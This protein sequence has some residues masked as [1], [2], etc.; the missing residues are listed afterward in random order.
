MADRGFLG[1]Y[2]GPHAVFAWRDLP[3]RLA[4]AFP[5]Y[6]VAFTDRYWL[7]PDDADARERYHAALR[8]W[9]PRVPRENWV[10]GGAAGPPAGV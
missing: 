3:E 2:R 8:A 6:A 7:N 5:L 1:A 4:V 9:C 10:F